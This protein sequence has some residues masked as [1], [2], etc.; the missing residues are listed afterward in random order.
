MDRIIDSF[1]F[2]KNREELKQEELKQKKLKQEKLK[3]EELKQEELK[4]KKLKQEELKQEEL[5]Q[6]ELKLE[7]IRN[8]N[9]KLREER[10]TNI[11]KIRAEAKQFQDEKD[12][13]NIDSHKLQL[14]KK[15]NDIYAESFKTDNICTYYI[16]CATAKT[17]KTYL[18]NIIENNNINTTYAIP[19]AYSIYVYFINS[20]KLFNHM[21]KG[22]IIKF[23]LVNKTYTI[24]YKP[25]FSLKNTTIDINFTNLCIKT[26][27]K[28]YNLFGITTQNF[29]KDERC[30]TEINKVISK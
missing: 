13:F 23:D 1:D 12:Q 10:N 30:Y 24:M 2:L 20:Y 28:I 19:A 21:Y 27:E 3:Q 8:Q 26:E 6:E 5:K 15:I 16:D 4:Q 9:K 17:L 25:K 11:A 29:N 22:K 7:Y 14:D 18:K